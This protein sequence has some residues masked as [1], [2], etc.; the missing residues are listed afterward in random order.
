MSTASIVGL[1]LLICGVLTALMAWLIHLQTRDT[2]GTFNVLGKTAHRRQGHTLHDQ[3]ILI[4]EGP[5]QVTVTHIEGRGP[6][7]TLEAAVPG[8]DQYPQAFHPLKLAAQD[9]APIHTGET[10]PTLHFADPKSSGKVWARITGSDHFQ[11]GDTE[12]D[13]KVRATGRS[14]EVFDALTRHPKVRRAIMALLNAGYERVT[15]FD[16]DAPV[17]VTSMH[18]VPSSDGPVLDHHTHLL[19]V[20][21]DHLPQISDQRQVH[22]QPP[23]GQWTL[24]SNL[25]QDA[26]SADAQEVVAAQPMEASIERGD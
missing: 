17:L 3:A 10:S 15:I 20:I 24:P 8:D 25:V 18:P 14:R 22:N 2:S 9:A 26:D 5:Y 23:P 6:R 12:F 13:A 4:Q 7:F 16:D 21:M 11:S 19:A 1:L